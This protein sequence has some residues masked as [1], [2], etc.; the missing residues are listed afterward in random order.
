MIV[1]P[2]AKRAARIA[3][4]IDRGSRTYA[5]AMAGSSL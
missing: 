2:S 1:S 5:A 4:A 3:Q